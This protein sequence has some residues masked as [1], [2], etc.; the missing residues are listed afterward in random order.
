V[1]ARIA[2]DVAALAVDGVWRVLPRVRA[3]SGAKFAADGRLL[4][5]RGAK[6]LISPDGGEPEECTRR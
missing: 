2:P 4:W 5:D 3:A 6:A 1:T